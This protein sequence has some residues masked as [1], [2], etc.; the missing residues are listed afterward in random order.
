M[1]GFYNALFVIF[2]GYNNIGW[3]WKKILNNKNNIPQKQNN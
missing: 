2:A 1:N 3:E